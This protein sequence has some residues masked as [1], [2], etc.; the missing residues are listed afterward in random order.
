MPVSDWTKEPDWDLLFLN[1]EICPGVA[2]VR[3]KLKSGLDVK[4][5]RKQKKARITDEGVHPTE[6]EIEVE[7]LPEEMPDFQARIIPLLRPRAKND[8]RAKIAIAHPTA[9]LWGVDSVMVG[10]VRSGHPD[11]GGTVK[12]S[13]DCIEWRDQPTKQKKATPKPAA[14][15]ADGHDVQNIIDE[16]S[17][18]KSGAAQDN[19][20]APR[21]YS[22]TYDPVTPSGPFS[23]Q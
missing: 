18:S 2:R 16:E 19:F 1:G 8:E 3:A 20:S 10:D 9:Q 11:P 13:F 14:D 7:L 12:V 4:K 22:G 15:N 6:L 17:P 5:P 23:S 21:D